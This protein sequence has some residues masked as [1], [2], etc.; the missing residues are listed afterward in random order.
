MESNAVDVKN[1]II[2]RRSVEVKLTT[3]EEM[4]YLEPGASK[5]PQDNSNVS[6]VIECETQANLD[7][8]EDTECAEPPPENHPVETSMPKSP[9]KK[10]ARWISKLNIFIMYYKIK[11]QFRL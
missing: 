3:N 11:F 10:K 4:V 9:S 5:R 2:S 6:E 8:P 7:L 1:E